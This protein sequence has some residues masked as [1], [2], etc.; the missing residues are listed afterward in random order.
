M[1]PVICELMCRLIAW[2]LAASQEWPQVKR[3]WREISPGK[4]DGVSFLPCT[5]NCEQE[6]ARKRIKTCACA[7]WDCVIRLQSSACS[8][9]PM[10]FRYWATV[11]EVYHYWT[12]VGLWIF[13]FPLFHSAA[14]M[15]ASRWWPVWLGK[16]RL[17]HVACDRPSIWP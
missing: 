13:C 8:F 7:E 5:C 17:L 16:G 3:Q 12:N 9:S 10:L 2:P 11:A 4:Q 15:A 6:A 1:I 14:I